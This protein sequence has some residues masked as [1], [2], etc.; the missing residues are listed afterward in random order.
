[1]AIFS[2]ITKFSLT[3]HCFNHRL[4]PLKLLYS[5]KKIREN[6]FIN[7][8]SAHHIFIKA[9][10]I[11]RSTDFSSL[12]LFFLHSLMLTQTQRANPFCTF[13]SS[14]CTLFCLTTTHV[15]KLKCRKKMIYETKK[16]SLYLLFYIYP[17]DAVLRLL[18]NGLDKLRVQTS[19][20]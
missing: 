11:M 19:G 3:F 15:T 5:K 17:F 2:R 1:M 20:I 16:V 13:N 7:F 10:V 14:K 6:T 18:A 4:D 12:S 8:C 9:L